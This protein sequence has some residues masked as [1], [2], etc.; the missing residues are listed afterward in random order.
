MDL[1]DK[2]RPG[3]RIVGPDDH[4]YGGI[5]RYDDEAVY[6]GGRRVPFDAI[7]RLDAHRLHLSTA[8]AYALIEQEAASVG[9]GGAVRV[10]IHQERVEVD[11]RRIDLGEIRVH[12][13]VEEVEEVR[14]GPLDREDVQIERV[15][16]DRPVSVPEERRQEGD[17][18][19][20]PVMAE[21]F[22]VRKQLVVT[23]EIRIR[24]VRVTEEGEIRETVRRERASI[25][26]TRAGVPPSA[27]MPHQAA[28]TAEEDTAWEALHEEI[29]GTER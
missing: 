12:K 4:D 9:S 24:K 28:A 11:T 21:I 22:V 10:P 27:P 25:E 18:L 6:L 20:I 5:D 15:R 17:W 2:L 3:M 26:D 1:K 16:V 8:G 29:R 13:T 19:I 14:R 23:E 7:E